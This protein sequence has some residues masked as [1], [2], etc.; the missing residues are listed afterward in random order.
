MFGLTDLLFEAQKSLLLTV[1]K[2]PCKKGKM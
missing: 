1:S 2:V